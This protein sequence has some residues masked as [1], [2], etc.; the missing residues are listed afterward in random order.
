MVVQYFSSEEMD[1]AGEQ[2][3]DHQGVKTALTTR[4]SPAA[5]LGLFV[6]A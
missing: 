1:F 5:Q 3:A 6:P 2:H 4:F